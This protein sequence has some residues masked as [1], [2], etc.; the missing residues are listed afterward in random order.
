MSLAGLTLN[1]SDTFQQGLLGLLC[2][3]CLLFWDLVSHLAL[4]AFSLALLGSKR[5]EHA[6]LCFDLRD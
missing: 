6:N 2:S 4:E 5:I 3:K 1:V